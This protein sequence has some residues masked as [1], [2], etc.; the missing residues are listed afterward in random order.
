MNDVVHRYHKY[1]NI[2][3]ITA[4][5]YELKRK[6][7]AHS[8]KGCEEEWLCNKLPTPTISEICSG[9]RFIYNEMLYCRYCILLSCIQCQASNKIT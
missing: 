7:E 9:T 5:S 3:K 4:P 2:T 1:F 6:Y 8:A